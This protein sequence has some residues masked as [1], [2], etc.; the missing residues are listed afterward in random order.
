MIVSLGVAFFGFIF[1]ICSASGF[2]AFTA[3]LCPLGSSKALGLLLTLRGCLR[4]RKCFPRLCSPASHLL[5][6]GPPATIRH[7]LPTGH[8]EHCPSHL[9]AGHPLPASSSPMI[10]VGARTLWSTG[11]S[12]LPRPVLPGCPQPCCG[13]VPLVCCRAIWGLGGR[14]ESLAPGMKNTCWGC[15]PG[16]LTRPPV[17]LGGSV[18]IW[19]N[20][21]RP[22][23]L[24]ATRLGPKT[25]ALVAFCH[26]EGVVST[27]ATALFLQPR[28]PHQL[29]LF[30]PF[31]VQGASQLTPGFP[32]VLG[33]ESRERGAQTSSLWK[34]LSVGVVCLIDGWVHLF[35]LVLIF[36]TI[37]VDLIFK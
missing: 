28:V 16:A 32:A 21:S 27:W 12:A 23:K 1:G 11:Q 13:R 15:M 14:R 24:S 30:L 31:R 34:S 20:V 5:G 18:S 8:K 7:L 26:W 6:R 37:S 3:L 35:L 17:W 4:S 2:R 33:G 36:N 19:R 10:W 9:W 25:L 29:F 22:A